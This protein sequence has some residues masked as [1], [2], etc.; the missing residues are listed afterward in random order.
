MYACPQSLAPRSLLADMKA[1]LRK[2]GVRPP[3]GVTPAPVSSA[4]DYRKVP[5]ERLTAR[6][7]LTRYD[8]EAPLDGTLRPAARI[9]LLLSQHMG[10]PAQAIVRPGDA[11]TRGQMVAKPA[12]GLS[13]AVHTGIC[14]T[15]TEVTDRYIEI[16]AGKGRAEL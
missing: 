6:L 12:E 7:G 10:A 2:S 11:V 8:R 4:R 9:R 3:Q 1:G 14:G 5:E 13:V 15:V 16:I